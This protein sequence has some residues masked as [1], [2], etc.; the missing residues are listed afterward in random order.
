MASGRAS[1]RLKF[2]ISALSNELERKGMILP[3]T[4]RGA[5]IKYVD[6]EP[7]QIESVSE[8]DNGL[9]QIR[10]CVFIIEIFRYV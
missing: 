1:A 3:E 5:V 6:R 4:S 8:S 10:E 7:L 9:R 2:A